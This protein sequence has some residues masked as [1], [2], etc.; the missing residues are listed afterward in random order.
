MKSLLRITLSAFVVFTA[1]RGIG[2]SKPPT[3]KIKPSEEGG[4]LAVFT[5]LFSAKGVGV[6]LAPKR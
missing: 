6:F 3:A 2:E 1:I 5:E 4:D